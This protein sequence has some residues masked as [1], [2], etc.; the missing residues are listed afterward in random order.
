MLVQRVAMQLV[1]A[2]SSPRRQQIL[3]NLGVT[4]QT[5]EPRPEAERSLPRHL[6]LQ[7]LLHLLPEVSQGKA[8]DVASRFEGA[9]LVVAADTVVFAQGEVLNKPGGNLLA[10]RHLEKLS[11]RAHRV[12]TSVTVMHTETGMLYSEVESTE[13]RFRELTSDD[14]ETYLGTGEPLDKAG[15]YGIQGWGCLLVA[16][17][18]GRY[19]NVVGFPMGTLEKLLA[20]HGVSLYHFRSPC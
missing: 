6:P 15:S 20:L 17:I 19:D 4:F 18:K 11:G 3:Q 8:V 9:A 12:L 2:S 14:I 7:R 13:V 5:R 10:R 16:S 1:L